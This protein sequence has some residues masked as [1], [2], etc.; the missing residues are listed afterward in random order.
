MNSFQYNENKNH[1]DFPDLL[2][3]RKLYKN[4][5]CSV[6]DYMRSQYGSFCVHGL[7]HN[8]VN[9]GNTC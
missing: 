6:T 4:A 8:F 7:S 9:F 2:P 1:V 5:V 3:R